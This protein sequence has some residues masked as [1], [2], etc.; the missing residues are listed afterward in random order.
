MGK[1][2]VQ[3]RSLNETG[4]GMWGAKD[5]G[6]LGTRDNL[7][8]IQGRWWALNPINQIV[9]PLPKATESATRQLLTCAASPGTSLPRW[10]PG[11][12]AL[13]RIAHLSDCSDPA[14]A[15]VPS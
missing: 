6:L 5:K 2:K 4:I 15:S 12:A 11:G 13:S 1:Q 10:G 8:D 3:V 9:Q 7:E 14:A